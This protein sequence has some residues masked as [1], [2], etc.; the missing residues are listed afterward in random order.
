MEVYIEVTYFLNALLLFFSFEILSFLLNINISLKEMLK[1]MLTYN[2][3]IL[4]I[5]IDFFDGFLI[6]YFLIVSIVYFRKQV[7][8]YYPV[9][10]FIYISLLSFFDLCL[11]EMIS[12]Q[13][14]LLCEGFSI[15]SL[16]VV[17][18]FVIIA[19][20][21]YVYY[22]SITIKEIDNYVDIFIGGKQYIGFIDTGNKV[23]YKGYPLIFFNKKLLKDYN[24]I[25]YIEIKTAVNLDLV[26][27][28]KIQDITIN[29][30]LLHNIYIGLIEELD[31]DCILSPSLMG[32][33]I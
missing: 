6:F 7:Y 18:L 20:Y 9:F 21:F 26:P 14:I 12:Y 10:I 15:P 29:H 24:A 16:T 1:Y 5:Y 19:S 2:I 33:I 4:L 3:S 28:I 17:I 11:H 13:C 27:I 8:L 30:Q 22:C 32:G 25:D 23:T 31:Y